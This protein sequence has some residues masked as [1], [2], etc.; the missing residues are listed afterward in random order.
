MPTARLP[1][2]VFCD[3][4]ASRAGR[5]M[6]PTILASLPDQRKFLRIQFFLSWKLLIDPGFVVGSSLPYSIIYSTQAGKRERNFEKFS[7]H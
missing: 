1:Y 5:Y 6:S 7:W 4:E 3:E 2:I